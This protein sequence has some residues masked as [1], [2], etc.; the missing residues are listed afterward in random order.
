MIKRAAQARD[1]SLALRESVCAGA[2]EALMS[3]NPA[4]HDEI[5]VA[6]VADIAREVDL[7]VLAQGSM[8]RLVPQLSERIAVPVLSSPRSGVERVRDVL[9]ELAAPGE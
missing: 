5:V 4:K 6:A 9:G 1:K 8:A 2:F 3:G 7:V